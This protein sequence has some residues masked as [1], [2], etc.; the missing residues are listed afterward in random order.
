LSQQCVAP[1]YKKFYTS[2]TPAMSKWSAS[3]RMTAGV[4]VLL[5]CAPVADASRG[6]VDSGIEGNVQVAAAT[7]AM[8]VMQAEPAVM[9]SATVSPETAPVE[10]VK[11]MLDVLHRTEEAT[12][13]SLFLG[14]MPWVRMMRRWCDFRL[15]V[16]F[17]L[18]L[19]AFG[20]QTWG[21]Y[22]ELRKSMATMTKQEEEKLRQQA[23]MMATSPRAFVAAQNELVQQQQ[24]R[25]VTAQHQAPRRPLIAIQPEAGRRSHSSPATARAVQPK[26]RRTQSVGPF[27]S[28]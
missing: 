15:M 21:S 28:R 22:L 23:S 7:E 25:H 16:I 8:T 27:R 10:S 24:Q 12:H 3:M 20:R 6:D 9:K 26:D 4:L 19:F 2:L 14:P 13:D 18:A 11:S 1:F 5:M 17:G